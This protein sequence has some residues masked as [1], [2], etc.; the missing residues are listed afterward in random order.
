MLYDILDY[1]MP[2]LP[3]TGP[4]DIIV[5]LR[6]TSE[7]GTLAQLADE[8]GAVPSQIHAAIGR[9]ATAGLLRPGA[10]GTN[11]RALLEFLT[12]GV[13]FAF[14][15]QKSVLATGVPTAYSAPPLSAEFDA[16][17]V[18]VWPAPLHPAA[19]QGFSIAPLSRA[20]HTLI[21]RSPTTYRLLC[22]TDAL[23]LDDARVRVTAAARLGL[24]L[25]VRA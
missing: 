2:K 12:H 17:D 3:R 1:R 11:A 15:A 24:M 8:L 14:P 19:V 20:A 21:D 25:G 10:R 4:F 23:R 7:A 16:L 22:V 13:R 5:A 9:L 18:L 6:L